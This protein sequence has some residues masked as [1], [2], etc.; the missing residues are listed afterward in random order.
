MQREDPPAIPQLAVPVT[1]PTELA[2]LAYTTDD[3]KMQAIGNLAITTFY[4]LLQVGEYTQPK[5]LF[6]NGHKVQAT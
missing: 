6:I 4:F 3:T 1:V 2:K 5:F